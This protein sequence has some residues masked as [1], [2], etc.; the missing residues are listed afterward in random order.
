LCFISSH[1][2]RTKLFPQRINCKPIWYVFIIL[3]RGVHYKNIFLSNIISFRIIKIFKKNI[4]DV[5]NLILIV[6]FMAR[7]V[8]GISVFS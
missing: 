7:L 4:F 1:S 3:S 6:L 8:I 5:L 2:Q